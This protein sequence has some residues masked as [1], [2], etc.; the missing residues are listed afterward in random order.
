MIMNGHA[1]KIL[2]IRRCKH[3]FYHK[4]YAYMSNSKIILGFSTFDLIGDI[5]IYFYIA[6]LQINNMMKLSDQ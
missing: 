3:I 4:I 1:I 5:E 6:K 2:R